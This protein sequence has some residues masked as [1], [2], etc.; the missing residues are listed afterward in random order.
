MV[1]RHLKQRIL[2]LAGHFPVIAILGARQVGKTTLAKMLMGELGKKV[3]YLDLENPADLAKLDNA[4]YFFQTNQDSCLIIDEVQRR[5][6]LFPILRSAIDQFRKPARFILLGS[7][8]PEL[9]RQS[10]ETLAGRIVYTELT[11]FTFPEI[12]KI[13]GQNFH[14]LCGGFPEPFLMTDSEIR[15]EWFTSFIRTYLERDLPALGLNTSA[16]Q[17]LRFVTM[18]AHTHGQILNKSNLAKA[19][20]LSVPTISNHGDFLEKAFLIRTLRPY[21]VNLKKR[22]VKS[23]KV[24]IRDSGLLHH[25]LRIEDY[26]SLLGH[27]A[28]GHSWEGYVIEQIASTL[29]DKFEYHFYRTQDGAECDLLITEQFKPLACVEIKFTSTPKK[30]KSLT[31]AVQDL[32]TDK[33]FIVIPECLDPYPLDENVMVCSLEQFLRQ[34]TNNHAAELQSQ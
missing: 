2:R 16:L 9:M 22:L 34:F 29:G 3:V 23:S 18:L 5:T 12:H 4:W 32:K 33:N 7:A 11:P 10:S 28:V 30:T 19:L 31:V 15:K 14:W 13:S 27:P 6:E 25:L 26:N 24:Y 17:L 20:E 21:F 1:E 8:S